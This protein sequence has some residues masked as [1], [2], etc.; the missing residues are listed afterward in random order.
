MWICPVCQK[1]NIDYA[2][3]CLSC[4]TGKLCNNCSTPF[5]GDVCKQCGKDTDTP[6][7]MTE[8]EYE[9]YIS[10]VTAIIEENAAQESVAEEPAAE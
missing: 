1:E 8:K 7:W 5:T 9:Q 6:I 3:R 2:H 4:M 10:S